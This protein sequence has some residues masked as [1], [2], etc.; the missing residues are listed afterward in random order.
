VSCGARMPCFLINIGSMCCSGLSKILLYSA[1]LGTGSPPWY[2]M[3]DRRSIRSKGIFII[4][5]RHSAVFLQCSSVLRVAYPT[6]RGLPPCERNP[7]FRAIATHVVFLHCSGWHATRR[8]YPWWDVRFSSG[9]DQ[10]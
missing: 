5:C 3:S 1:L 4:A 9:V 8:M 6:D 10:I 2:L 7:S